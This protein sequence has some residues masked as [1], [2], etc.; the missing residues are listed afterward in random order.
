MENSETIFSIMC[1]WSKELSLWIH[2]NR[3]LINEDPSGD[4]RWNGKLASSEDFAGIIEFIVRARN[5]LFH[6][7]KEPSEEIDQQV[8]GCAIV[9]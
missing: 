1:P 4:Q 8:V 5:N 3:P 2:L 7:D 6:G 9:S